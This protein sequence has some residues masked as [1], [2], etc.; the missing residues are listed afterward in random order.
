MKTKEEK[1]A[2]RPWVTES[3]RKSLFKRFPNIGKYKL[4]FGP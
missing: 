2:I 1:L 4:K 3:F